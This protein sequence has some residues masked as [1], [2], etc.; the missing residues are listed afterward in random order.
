MLYTYDTHVHICLCI[1]IY[2]HTCI[3]MWLYIYMYVC[4]Y[5]N[6]CMYIY[7]YMYVYIL[8]IKWNI[9]IV[10]MEYWWF[11]RREFDS[12]PMV[13]QSSVES[14]NEG[15]FLDD[16]FVYRW[17]ITMHDYCNTNLQYLYTRFFSIQRIGLFQRKTAGKAS[18]FGGSWTPVPSRFSTP[19]HI[20]LLVIQ[21][22]F[23][24]QLHPNCIFPARTH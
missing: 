16:T 5:M 1:Y 18:Q 2:I 22:F 24:S 4:M 11:S 19:I 3:Y 21:A 10:L 12:H 13:H 23:R 20:R 15:G 14:A 6:V 9:S 7:I 8:E 17:F